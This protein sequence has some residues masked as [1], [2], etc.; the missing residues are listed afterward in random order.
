MGRPGEPGPARLGHP[1]EAP[2]RGGSGSAALPGRGRPSRAAGARGR[3]AEL[4]A[5]TGRG[6]HRSV[7]SQLV[8]TQ[9]REAPRRGQ[10]SP[11]AARRADAERLALPGK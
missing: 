1:E 2:L 11:P 6:G 8:S 4:G 3:E 9:E 10:Q 5:S 7:F